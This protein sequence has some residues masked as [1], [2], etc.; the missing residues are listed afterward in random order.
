MQCI[1]TFSLLRYNY[2]CTRGDRERIQARSV[3][4]RSKEVRRLLKGGVNVVVGVDCSSCRSLVHAAH[5][6]GHHETRWSTCKDRG[7]CS[8][9]A[10]QLGCNCFSKNGKDENWAKSIFGAVQ[11]GDDVDMPLW[12]T[13]FDFTMPAGEWQEQRGCTYY[14]VEFWCSLKVAT[15]GTRDQ[16][17]SGNG[18]V[19]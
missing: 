19:E 1:S 9:G 17:T 3:F 5:G 8:T 10:V 18:T 6:N 14:N 11:G 16:S 4:G 12:W 13:F 15:V 2:N 7:C